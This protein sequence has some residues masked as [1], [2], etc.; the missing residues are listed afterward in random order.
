M[1]A[2]LPHP[3]KFNVEG[4]D[5]HL[6]S[7]NGVV[8]AVA[9]GVGGWADIGIDAGQYS[10][11][12]MSNAEEC[13]IRTGTSDP[14]TILSEAFEGTKSE[15]TCT[16]CIIS[17]DGDSLR[18]ANLGDSG[19]MVL[20]HVYGTRWRLVFR[21]KEQTHYFN[22]PFQ[23]GT[24]SQD[25]PIDAQNL[26]VPVQKGDLVVAAT[27]GL[28]DN[29]FN[30]E[31]LSLLDARGVKPPKFSG[32]PDDCDSSSSNGDGDGEG[33]GDGDSSG[34]CEAEEEE[35]VCDVVT[36]DAADDGAEGVTPEEVAKCALED[37]KGVSIA[38]AL[39]KRALDLAQK[40]LRRSPF[41]VNA[42]R[43]GYEF[44]G[45]KMDDITVIT[46]FVC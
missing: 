44:I 39:A 11:E 25:R 2:Y 40:P 46:A 24:N 38:G 26:V 8:I 34:I 6:I 28:F 41:A 4:E 3:D 23:L 9:D 31:V 37:E 12:L 14:A 45:G 15:G 5:A 32:E 10:R 27:D 42:K 21:S 20:R 36:G 13:I 43:A 29:M 1:A 30:E 19:L 17:L 7:E 22:C 35:E 33:N 16:A 18:A